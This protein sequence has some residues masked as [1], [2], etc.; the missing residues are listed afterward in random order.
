VPHRFA[1]GNIAGGLT[2]ISDAFFRVGYLGVPLFMML[3]GLSLT[4]VLLTLPVF[5][6]VVT[7][8]GFDPVWFGVLIVLVVQIGLISPPVGMNLFV[9]NA[10][11]KDVSLPHIFRGVWLFVG[12]LVVALFVCLEFQGLSLWLPSFMR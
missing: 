6:P 4:M 7:A 10:L 8:L 1:E 3:S 9:L 5:F 11:L 2:A 12:A